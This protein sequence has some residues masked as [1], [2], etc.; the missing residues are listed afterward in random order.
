MKSKRRHEL[1]E[2]TL[3]HEFSRIRQFFSNWGNHITWGLLIAAVIFAIGY[4]GWT[5][6]RRAQRELVVRVSRLQHIRV[7]RD[8][9]IVELRDLAAQ[10]GNRRVAAQA[11]VLLGNAYYARHLFGNE[12]V[13]DQEREEAVAQAEEAFRDVITHYEDFPRQVSRARYALAKLL[14][15]QDRFDEARE[16]YQAI[17]EM[18]AMEGDPIVQMAGEAIDALD[19][20]AEP[21]T[22]AD[23]PAQPMFEPTVPDD[24]GMVPDV[25]PA[26]PDMDI[27]SELPPDV[28]PEQVPE[29]PPESDMPEQPPLE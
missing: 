22:F 6:H 16:H 20:L 13:T 18:D 25:P 12:E 21:V 7:P 17:V 11:S 23:V 4:Y 19:E 5:R 27:P 14:K 8:E 29:S 3:A 28:M 26:D 24:P 2:N 10:Q 9:D 1:K 15:N